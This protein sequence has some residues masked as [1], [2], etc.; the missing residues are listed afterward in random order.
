MEENQTSVT[1][2]TGFRKFSDAFPAPWPD[3]NS[4]PVSLYMFAL[5]LGRLFLNYINKVS[6]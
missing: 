4:L 2:W 1:P 5:F 6:G 3:S